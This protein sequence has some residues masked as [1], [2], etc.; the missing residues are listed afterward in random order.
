MPENQPTGSEQKPHSEHEIAEYY[1]GVKELEMKGHE[2][3]IK[4]A[5]GALFATAALF[6]IGEIISASV[7]G[8]PW[9]PVLI[10]IV[11]VEVGVFVALGFWT[12]TKPFTAIIV[13]IDFRLYRA[14]SYTVSVINLQ[15]QGLCH[16]PFP[17]V[18]SVVDDGRCGTGRNLAD[19]VS[20]W[21]GDCD[22]R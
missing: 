17:A 13:G 5:R 9:T 14:I 8:T 19:G 10:A 12:K 21:T 11:A 22:D 15:S 18:A 1:E 2:S 6:L 4:K 20:G 16:A 7:S 3:G